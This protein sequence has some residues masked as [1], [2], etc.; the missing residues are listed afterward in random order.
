MVGTVL[1][2]TALLLLLAVEWLGQIWPTTG[3]GQRMQLVAARLMAGVV[4]VAIVAGLLAH[5]APVA[6]GLRG[7]AAGRTSLP[8][9]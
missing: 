5:R 3:S 1:V 4:M 2:R 8:G 6:A 9:R 7:A